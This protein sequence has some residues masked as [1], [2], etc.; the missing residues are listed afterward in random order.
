MEAEETKT[1]CNPVPGRLPSAP[2][3]DLHTC[4]E[5]QRAAYLADPVPSLAQRQTHLQLLARFVRENQDAICGA[6]SADYG[7]RS[8]ET[9]LARSSTPFSMASRTPPAPALDEAAAPRHRPPGR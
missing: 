9:L 7:H 6:I 4:L 2:A 8:R 3:D 1:C 5:R